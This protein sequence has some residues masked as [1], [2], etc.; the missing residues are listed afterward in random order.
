M[1]ARLNMYGDNIFLRNSD[2]VYEWLQHHEFAATRP[3][4]LNEAS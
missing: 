4:K 1:V 3:T 2:M